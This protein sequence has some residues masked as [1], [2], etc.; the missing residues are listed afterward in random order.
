MSTKQRRKQFFRR[1]SWAF[2]HF[3]MLFTPWQFFQ[4]PKR[5]PQYWDNQWNQF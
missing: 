3:P 5:Q 2:D 1:L 4:Q